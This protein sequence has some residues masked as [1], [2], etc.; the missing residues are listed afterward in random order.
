MAQTWQPIGPGPL[1]G[2]Q[3]E[4][5]TNSPVIGAI[6]GIAPHPTNP[7]IIY[8][9]AVNGGVWKTSNATASSPTWTPQTDDK[10][11]MSMGDVEFDLL[12]PTFQ[13]LV[14][15][16]GRFSSLIST[17]G[18]RAGVFR[19]TDGGATWTDLNG[20]MDDRNITSV[21]AR[22]ATL[23]AAVTSADNNT[24]S[25]IGIFRSTNTGTSWTQLTTTQGI[26]RG[27]ASSLVADPLDNNTFFAGVS[28]FN[29]VCSAL[30]S[31]I[32]KTID[33]GVSWTK[34]SNAAMETVIGTSSCHFEIAVGKNVGTNVGETGNV[35]V[36]MVC[37]GG[38][39]SAVFRSGNA[40]STW[41]AMDI[42][43]TT[44]TSG[45]V[46]LHPGGQGTL[47]SSI[48]AD[49]TNDNI[50]YVGGDR[51]PDG[52]PGA[53]FPNSIGANTYSGRLFR[54]DFSQASGSQWT[55]LTH[56]GTA[57]NSS[58]HADSRDLQFDANGN[59]LEGDDGGIF[60]RSTPLSTSGD[61]FSVN[62]D[63]QVT[64]QHDTVYDANSEIV[65]SGNQDNGTSRQN[66]FAS[67]TWNNVRG[68]D[69]GDVVVDVL[70]L[71]GSNRSVRYDSFQN[72]QAFRR[73]TYD[74]N[75][76]FISQSSV[77]LNVINGGSS[78]SAQFVTPL[79]INNTNGNRLIIG[80]GNSVYESADQGDN[81]SEI[82]AGIVVAGFGR[83]NIAY[84]ASDNADILYVGACQGSC[85]SGSNDGVFVRTTA[86]GALTLSQAPSSGVI[87]GVT[88]NPGDSTEA[89]FIESAKVFH[90]TNSGTNWTE[91]TGNLTNFGELR[92]VAFMPDA[93]NSQLV[94]GTNR[95]VF[96]AEQADAFNM[97]SII[98][99]GM[100]NT[101]VFELQYDAASDRLIAGTMG[102]GSFVLTSMMGSNSP[103]VIG[104]ETISV[105]KGGTA[106]T[107]DGGATSLIVNDTD[108]DAGDTLTMST[109]A[110]TEPMNGLLS[111][112]ANG[113]FSYQHDDSFT[114]TDQFFY[115]VCDDGTPEMCADGQVDITVDLGGAV[116]SAP[117]LNIPDDEPV[118][119]VSDTLAVATSGNLTDL[120][121]FL[122]INHTWVGDVT[123]SLTHVS[124]GTE[125]VLLERPGNPASTNG[126]SANDIS[127][128]LDDDSATP[129]EDQCAT[130][131]A[132]TGILSPTEALSGFNGQELSGNW[133]LKVTDSVGGDDGAL[134]SWC[135]S[136]TIGAGPMPPV[137][138]SIGN[139]DVNELVNL[140]FTATATDDD[141]AQNDLVFS[142]SGE[143]TGASITSGGAFSFTPT[144]AQ[145][146]GTYT[147]D[148]VV[149]DDTLP[150]ALTDSE[151]I[152][153]TVA[154]VN[155]NPVLGVIG[156]QN[157]DELSLLT[158]NASATDAD[159][160]A[161]SLTYT[162]SGE[163]SGASITSGGVFSFT[164]TEAQG[165]GDYTFDVIV[166]DNGNGSLADSEEITVTVAELNVPPSLN[167]IGNQI[168]EVLETLSFTVSATDTDLPAQNLTFSL[169]GEP[170]G[171]SITSGGD[172]S[173]TPTFDQ[174]PG[175][176]TFDVIVNDNFVI[177]NEA[178]SD[179]ETIT[180]EVTN[181]D[182]IFKN[183]FE[184]PPP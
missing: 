141:T 164:P 88:V 142:L 124:S 31:G 28:T 107:V 150:T 168:V 79:A 139:K 177:T 96:K 52:L 11:S 85:F 80:G 86:A 158:F 153:V 53:Q 51:Q 90:T 172:F 133:T 9:A 2:G 178:L 77:A 35:F 7:D 39:L 74:Q 146:P 19:T 5:M 140:A 84:G 134:I 95:G 50:V 99:P 20:G 82:G 92:S 104:A 91:I 64:E 126:C 106:T 113:T 105:T 120:N 66:L 111:L 117:N 34:V 46:G 22:G 89:F 167:G 76:G 97:W 155:Q 114:D 136:P 71:A 45:T 65:L 83:N 26:P 30:A 16:S 4:G 130:P 110:V 125:V 162:L 14:A 21:E 25:N 108:P 33:A 68:G 101:P 103:P 44:E 183:A 94:V 40:G 109:T 174:G 93:S 72:L 166:T 48:A 6:H 131:I 123:V 119:G 36:S 118:T 175:M 61:W 157:V 156:N 102:R 62:G 116:C 47:H 151:E 78:L 49:P 42:P 56:N 17:G 145:G 181:G 37:G 161:Q 170:A 169:L 57:S 75:N 173:F 32:Y 163:P 60:R 23:L 98:A 138:A 70:S 59:L 24:C 87:Q 73:L 27:A 184:A 132:I 38:N 128:T 159:L 179:S 81:I 69:G 3:N 147:F 152:T 63:L 1:H 55:P 29:G 121:V 41:T 143:P 160:P 180:V 129:A 135:L 12:D 171:A 149:S 165:P 137:L 144:E 176:Y 54:G 8:V 182:L 154:E 43:E 67:T 115:R 18:D 15:G 100:P 112:S 10:S 122:E 148:V 127:T 13:T 58:P